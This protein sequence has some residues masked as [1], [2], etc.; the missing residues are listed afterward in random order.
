MSQSLL[1]VRLY[2]KIESCGS[3]AQMILNFFD[4]QFRA[5]SVDPDQT[6]LTG[7]IFLQTGHIKTI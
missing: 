6:P 5:N 4:R 3:S 7:S 1:Q 2:N